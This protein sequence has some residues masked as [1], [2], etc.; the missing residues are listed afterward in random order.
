MIHHVVISERPRS[1][2]LQL[3][4]LLWAY[5]EIPN[6][7]TGL[8]PFSLVYGRAARG[9]L[10]I[11]RDRWSS[12]VPPLV[13]TPTVEAR[14]YLEQLKVDLTNA[15][16]IAHENCEAAQQAY[17]QQYNKRCKDKEFC[18]GDLVL[19]L[20]PDSSN[21]LVSQWVGPATVVSVVS[22][23]SYR[24]ALDSGSI[25]TLHANRLR[26]F[27]SRINTVGVIYEEDSDFGDLECC[28]YRDASQDAAKVVV[29]NIET[30]DLNH[31]TQHQARQLKDLLIKHKN[32]FS[33]RPGT[34]DVVPHKIDLVEGFQPKALRP[35]KIPEALKPEI[36]KQIQQLLDDGKIRPSRSPFAHPIVC[37]KKA[38]SSD[39][40]M[41]VDL[42]YVNSGVVKDSYPMPSGEDLLMRM[43]PANF[44]STLDCSQGFYQVPLVE[45]DAYKTAFIS[46][47]GHFE[48]L[49]S[50]FGISTA[51]A[52]FQ[53]VMDDLLR[54][55]SAYSGAYIDD[56]SVFSI[57]WHEHLVHLDAVLSDYERVGMS[58]KFSKCKWALP[59]VKFIGHM[60]GSGRRSP[61]LDKVEAIRAIPE[62]RTKKLLRGFLGCCGF[63]RMY[64]PKYSDIAF[65]LTE[66]TK[67]SQSN[68]ISFNETQ[69]NAFL[70]LKDRLCNCSE[71]YA[72]VYGKPFHLFCDASDYALGGA[73]TQVAEDGE[74][75]CPVAFVSCK[76]S[77][78]Q[79][80]WPCIHKE[81]YAVIYCLQKLEHIVYGAEINL[82]TDHNP[83]AYLTVT[84]PQSAKLIRWA[85]SLSRFNIKI[86]H[87]EGKLNVVADFLSRGLL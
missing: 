23:Y 9:P 48:F 62:P 22:K 2:H 71:L 28:P 12:E 39:I 38:N 61:V 56:A 44:I 27:V 70:T 1:W 6:D 76:F 52:H 5:R 41:C 30:L 4:F 15:M 75:H 74:T 37:V 40:R 55:H 7:S 3:P 45:S 29:S 24:I 17:V 68:K 85:L 36:D 80:N 25:R 57:L 33:D 63:Y 13:D 34:C 66:L 78:T 69:R 11:L 73:L 47:R 42:R 79:M 35:Y 21:K 59:C 81:S 8:S 18:V 16:D 84:V 43:C 54:P 58:L 77:Q 46:H 49:V 32:V 64:I 86:R 72:V 26:K 82:W 60:V 10:S 83:L 67:G 31:L 65:P 19:V 53:R 51:P 87:I 20:L 14:A 50:P